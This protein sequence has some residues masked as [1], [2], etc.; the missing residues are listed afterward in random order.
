MI[1]NN[2]KGVHTERNAKR[3]ANLLERLDSR[4]SDL[5]KN[6]KMSQADAEA[7]MKCALQKIGAHVFGKYR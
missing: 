5:V 3:V 6:G 7:T 1:A 4:L 2:G